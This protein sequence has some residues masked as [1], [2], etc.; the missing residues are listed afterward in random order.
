MLAFDERSE[1][2]WPSIPAMV[3]DNARRFGAADAVVDGD[4][5]VSSTELVARV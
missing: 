1:V 4:R 3:R 5:R 2:T